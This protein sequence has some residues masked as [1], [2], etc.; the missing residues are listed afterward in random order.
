MNIL[1][2]T[3]AAAVVAA[4]M[5]IGPP[6]VVAADRFQDGMR[7]HE[8]GHFVTAIRLW[9]P[10]AE[11]GDVRAQFSLA[12]MYDLGHG[13][14]RDFAEAVKWF[15]LAAEQGHGDAQYNL[16]AMYTLG[17]GVARDYVKAHK[18]FNIAGVAGHERATDDRLSVTKKMTPSQI[19]K[20]QN[21]ALDWLAK[22]DQK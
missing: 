15:R 1:S 14:A 22:H 21:L 7:A 11:N 6:S 9:R 4:A 18:W 10:L 12:T 13:V 8:S 16:G 3:S 19:A 5:V 17:Y 2:Q 20:A